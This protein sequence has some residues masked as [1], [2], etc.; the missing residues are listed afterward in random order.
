MCDQSPDATCL[1]PCCFS[2]V[3]R[4]QHCSIRLMLLL[5]AHGAVFTANMSQAIASARKLAGDSFSRIFPVHEVTGRGAT[6]EDVV[7]L[8]QQL[9]DK[10]WEHKFR[11]N[12]Q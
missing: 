12:F 2:L 7:R 6:K 11:L 8:A 9:Q 3:L 1:V 5:C 10:A 4:W